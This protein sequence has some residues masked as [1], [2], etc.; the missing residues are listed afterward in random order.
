MLT[1]ILLIAILAVVIVLLVLDE[2]CVLDLPAPV[3]IMC[4]VL[5][6]AASIGLLGCL[7]SIGAVRAAAFEEYQNMVYEKEVL[8]Y[9]LEQIEN[10]TSVPGNELVYKDVVEF[11]NELRFIKKWSDNIWTSWFYNDIIAE[12]VEYIEIP[13]SNFSP[14]EIG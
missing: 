12:H 14:Q 10:G 1:T 9:R 8:E 13:N 5:V 4:M 7:C 2:R 3:G 6:F 11:N